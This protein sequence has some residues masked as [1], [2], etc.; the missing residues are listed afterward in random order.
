M[1][2]PFISM[3]LMLI[4]LTKIRRKYGQTVSISATAKHLNDAFAF[5]LMIWGV[6]VPLILA[7]F[8]KEDTPVMLVAGAFIAFMGISP[9]YWR[10]EWAEFVHVA[11]VIAGFIVAY[12]G[13]L[14]VYGPIEKMIGIVALIAVLIIVIAVNKNKT[15]WLEIALYLGVALSMFPWNKT[16]YY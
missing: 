10:D 16:P 12:Y 5:T 8:M 7:S 9:Q 4:Y 14:F 13:L 11:G 2:L 15:Y 1:I 3:F 6:V